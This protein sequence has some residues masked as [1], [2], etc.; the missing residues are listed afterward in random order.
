MKNRII[1]LLMTAAVILAL[2]P[3]SV[4][5]ASCKHSYGGA[6]WS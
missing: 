1:A 2:L 3:L 6:K 4:S 5:A